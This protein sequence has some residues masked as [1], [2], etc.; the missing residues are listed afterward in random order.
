MKKLLL[1]LALISS[2]SAFAI[3][4][5][6]E[7]S[8]A[9]LNTEISKISVQIDDNIIIKNPSILG[10]YRVSKVKEVYENGQFAVG[11]SSTL[12]MPQEMNHLLFVARRGLCVEGL[13]AGDR[14]SFKYSEGDLSESGIVV[15]F[16][17]ESEEDAWYPANRLRK[18]LIYRDRHEYFTDAPIKYMRKN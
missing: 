7:S 18:A 5:S 12:K 8:I 13:C 14:V 2:I 16:Q 11:S 4:E 1:G 6:D 9:E 17:I 10:S 3:C 15:G